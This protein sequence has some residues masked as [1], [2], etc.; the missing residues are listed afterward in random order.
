MKKNTKPTQYTIYDIP[1][2]QPRGFSIV[3]MLISVGVFAIVGIVITNSLSSSFKN[4][5]KSSA[6]SNVKSNIDYAISTIERLLRNAQSIDVVSSTATKLVYIDEFGNNTN[7]E[8]IS[9]APN[10]IA[11][12]SASVK[13]TSNQVIVDCVSVFSYPSPPP[14]VPQVVEISLKGTDKDIGAGVEG[15]SVTTKTRILLRNYID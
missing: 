2:T 10:Y 11:S 15:S 14:G 7:F 13:L 3:E 4:S 5:R 1:Y 8:C 6:I 9:G 12:G